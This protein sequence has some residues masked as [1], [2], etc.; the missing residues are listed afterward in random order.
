MKKIA[1]SHV[2]V[3]VSK[4]YLD[5]YVYP[6]N[7]TFR[8]VNNTRGLKR[9]LRILSSYDVKEITFEASGGYENLLLQMS[10]KAGYKVRLENAVNIR[11][12]A[13]ASKVRAKTDVLDAKVIAMFSAAIPSDYKKQVIG[14]TE[15]KLRELSRYKDVLQNNLTAEKHRLNGPM[16]YHSRVYIKKTILC[17]EKQIALIEKQ[18]A[19]LIEE[20]KTFKA[21]KEVMETMK[22]IGIAT[23][24]KLLAELPELGQLNQKEIASL[25]GVA[26]FTKES[27]EYKGLSRIR[28]GRPIPRKALY[29]AA[30]TASRHNAVFKCFYEKLIKKGKP[31]KVALV[32]IMR[33]I[34]V[35]LNGMLKKGTVW[36]PKIS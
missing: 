14:A 31:P 26:P 23:S 34:V 33:K 32:A 2:G 21:K 29:M 30:L 13:K 11:N 19:K 20:N 1:E 4:K 3:D 36:N 5:V 12:F 16:Y 7:K 25:V 15:A 10:N 24:T 17:L 35:T 6:N 9:F 27:G 8:I 18:I 22:G 28:D